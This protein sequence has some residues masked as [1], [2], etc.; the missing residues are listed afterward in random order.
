[1]VVVVLDWVAIM[2]CVNG[3][4]HVESSSRTGNNVRTVELNLR[5]DRE[6]DMMMLMIDVDD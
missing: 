4:V 5:K 3:N 1:M 6:V 2:L